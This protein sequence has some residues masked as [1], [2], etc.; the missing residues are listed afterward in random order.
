MLP[1]KSF[2][3]AEDSQRVNRE[4]IV[5]LNQFR[6]LMPS[7]ASG[8]VATTEAR[9]FRVPDNYGHRSPR[10]RLRSFSLQNHRSERLTKG[11]E[12]VLSVPDL[13]AIK[14]HRGSFEIEEKISAKSPRASD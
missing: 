14:V 8:K 10:L 1:I 5:R 7:P 6:H 4:G 12:T 2:R 11:S 3:N 13:G 9:A